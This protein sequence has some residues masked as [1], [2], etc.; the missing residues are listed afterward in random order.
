MD[1]W[2]EDGTL[3]VGEGGHPPLGP[4]LQRPYLGVCLGHQL[5]A[6]ALGGD[7]R[8]HG[9]PRVG[10]PDIVLTPDGRP[11]PSSAAC[12]PSCPGCNGITLSPR[13][14]GRGVVLAA[15]RR[16]HSNLPGRALA[17]GVQFHLE[18]G[19]EP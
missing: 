2:Q 6:D 7:G 18:V 3:D 5:L 12:R 10:V 1:V 11:M 9:L 14:P 13:A 16:A 4:E 17:G 19:A 15:T 8:R